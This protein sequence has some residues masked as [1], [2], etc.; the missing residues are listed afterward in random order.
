MIDLLINAIS[1]ALIFLTFY[2]VITGRNY[3]DQVEKHAISFFMLGLLFAAFRIGAEIASANGVHTI[4]L[5]TKV[6][7]VL[8]VLTPLC[9]IIGLKYMRDESREF[10]E[11]TR[12]ME[13]QAKFL[14]NIVK[15]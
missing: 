2:F 14:K 4:L 1:V 5:S 15:K 6:A 8:T 11:N 12:N 10:E 9:F 3:E 13:L 7:A